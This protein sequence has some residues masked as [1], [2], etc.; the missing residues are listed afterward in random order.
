[1]AY[2]IS[3]TD[4]STLLLLADGT[5]D[6]FATSLALIGRNV[7][8]YGQH[9]N[10]NLIKLLANS[11]NTAG[12][13]P[14]NPLKGQLWYDTTIR[15]LKVYDNGFKNVSGAIVDQATPQNLATGDV[16]YNSITAQLYVYNGTTSTTVG[17]VFPAN[18]GESGWV[19]P[20]PLIN[21]TLSNV[22]QV[23]SLKSHGQFLGFATKNGFD[24]S[25]ADTLTY[26]NTATTSTVVSGVTLNGSIKAYGNIEASGQITNRH[27]S[28]YFNIDQIAYNTSTVTTY[29][30]YVYQNE[31]LK[32]LLT[33]M[34]PVVS[35]TTTQ[36]VGLTLGSEVRVMCTYSNPSDGIGFQFRRFRVVND[37]FQGKSWQPCYFYNASWSS[38]LTNVMV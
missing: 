6:Q 28:A 23:I 19:L 7:N 30:E 22:Q 36:E 24:L 37:I 38:T 16:W 21:N 31:R 34:F 10:N 12:N 14:R 5:V 17:P 15:R 2:T 29:G 9:L 27:L 13:P 33:T 18:L 35:G 1:M 4:G 3:N 8:S 20:S 26:F 32:Q 25:A 11:A